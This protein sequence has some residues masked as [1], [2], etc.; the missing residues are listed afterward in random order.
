MMKQ[1]LKLLGILTISIM[2]ASL[3]GCRAKSVTEAEISWLFDRW[4]SAIQTGDPAKVVALYAAD[5]VLLPTLSNKPRLTPAEKEEYFV[6]F[7]K[8]RPSAKIDFRRIYVGPDMAVD[9][10]L[11]TFTF[12]RTGE[13]VSGRYSF[14]Y[15]RT[16]SGWRIVSH[17]SSLT[18][19]AN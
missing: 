4:N 7:L 18:P 15:R 6:H 11:Y 10:G 13:V 17:H 8:D 16:A 2:L 12:A 19:K 1:Y 5:S 9:S 14:V 3:T